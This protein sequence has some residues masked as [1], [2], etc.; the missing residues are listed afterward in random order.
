VKN[1]CLGILLLIWLVVGLARAD[2]W[3][4]D[5]SNAEES[6]TAWVGDWKHFAINKYGQLQSQVGEASES[7]LFHPNTCA[8]NAEWQCW[9]RISGA[10]STYNQVRF[11][12]TLFSNDIYDDGYFVQ[13]GGANK[14]ITLYEQKEGTSTKIIEHP[15]RIKCLDASASYV[16]VR[17]T[18]DEKGVFRLFSWIEGID[19]TWIEEGAIFVPMVRSAY[20]ALWVR[21][22]KT[23]GYDFY[24]DNVSVRGE[25][26]YQILGDESMGDKT[27]VQLLSENISPNHDGWEDEVCIQYSTPDDDY[28]ATCTVYTANGVLVKQLCQQ[29]AIPQIGTICWDGT[30]DKGTIA[31][32]GVYV[33]Y[34][35]LSST[36][37]HDTLRQRMAVSL[38]L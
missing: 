11:Y 9:V 25:E 5:F 29:T 27:S 15:D 21:N 30:T 3:Q 33:L 23:R 38:T 26:Q 17:A 12:L 8:I 2:E 10:C 35:E 24:I 6:N 37:T 18:R 14:N 31:E 4:D 13:I 32:I 7:A 36:T 20:T 19:T 1:K 22:S 34:I 16:S 28:R